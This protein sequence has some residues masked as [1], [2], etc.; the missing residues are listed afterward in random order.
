VTYHHGVVR[1]RGQPPPG[2]QLQLSSTDPLELRARRM[3]E[4]FSRLRMEVAEK[5]GQQALPWSPSEA[6][7]AKALALMRRIEPDRQAQLDVEPTMRLWLQRTSYSGIPKDHDPYWAFACWEQRRA[8]LA[9]EVRGLR[10]APV[11]G[12]T[13]KERQNLANTQ[14]WLAQ[15]QKQQEVTR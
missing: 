4:L 12:L 13:D 1:A 9:E 7:A 8:G 2:A 10:E 3:L 15:K 6:S 11:A 5:R 14:L